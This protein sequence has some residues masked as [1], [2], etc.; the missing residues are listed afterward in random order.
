MKKLLTTVMALALCGGLSCAKVD[1]DEI[2]V[3]V[4][5]VPFINC[6]ETSPKLTG[7]HLYIPKVHDFYILP[8]TYQKLDMTETGEIQ[9]QQA[10]LGVAVKPANADQEMQQLLDA[11]GMD[12]VQQDIREKNR[13]QIAVHDR[14]TG[15]QSVRIKTADGNDAW[16]NVVVVY[17]VLPE[18]AWLVV[19]KVGLDTDRIAS[20][21]GVMVRG[22]LRS[23]LGEL[24]SP[25]LLRAEDRRLQVEGD[26]RRDG[27]VN[28]EGA[29]QE[30]NRRLVVYGIEV[31]S[32]TAPSVT[33]HPDYAAVIKRKQVAEEDR[34][35][36]LSLQ[37]H[38][39]QE[40]ETKINRARGESD[41]QIEIARGR[42]AAT[43]QRA[44][45]EYEVRRLQAEADRVH[46]N[47]IGA[48]LAAVTSQLA[49]PGGSNQVAL[50]ITEA[51][52][53]K[54]II[55]LPAQGSI[56]TLDMNALISNY[57]AEQ[58]VK[59]NRE[60]LGPPAP[61]KTPTTLA[62]LPSGADHNP[63]PA[64]P[65]PVSP[66]PANGSGGQSK[67]APMQQTAQ[68]PQAQVQQAAPEVKR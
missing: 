2:G 23:R 15:N 41:A 10:G 67:A 45:A 62:P 56:N 63:A 64:L 26:V 43:I 61:P 34:Y 48:G 3:R 31:Q 53:G 38:A 54:R 25:E 14:R 42:L 50:A 52:Q 4:L 55:I 17:H 65:P 11:T 5:N 33:V 1:S 16:V 60:P 46:Y 27:K 28:R 36:Y 37:A 8:R 57:A 12:L 20:I 58:I 49:G 39:K 13:V 7:Y 44:D 22:T 32:L 47:E 18:R 59:K 30:L 19:Q 51:L 29:L 9:L 24:T 40:K 35:T 6:I 21:V 68:A 66:K